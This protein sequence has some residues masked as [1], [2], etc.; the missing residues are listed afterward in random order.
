MPSSL[1]HRF[2]DGAVEAIVQ[3]D[4]YR[5]EVITLQHQAVIAVDVGHT[6]PSGERGRGI[7]PQITEGDDLSLCNGGL[8]LRMRGADLSGSDHTDSDLVV[9][10]RR[11]LA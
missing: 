11:S 8:R 6:K 10:G 9:H 4:V 1:E 7:L 5:M 2:C 3:A